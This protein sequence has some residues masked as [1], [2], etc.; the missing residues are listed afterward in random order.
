[1]SDRRREQSTPPP[2]DADALAR[3]T[4]SS[5]FRGYDID[6]VRAYLLAL[7]ED[8]RAMNEHTS[9]LTVELADAEQRATAH[10]E[11]DE[12][13]L[14][15]LLGEETA[16]VLATA[17]EAAASIRTRAD[18]EA[19]RV[20]S[21][22]NEQAT[23]IRTEALSDAIRHRERAETAA[24]AEV[25]A[26]KAHGRQLITDAQA[27]REHVLADLTRRR[28][29][30]RAQ[31]AHLKEGRDR[32]L[33]AYE[34]VRR[35]LEQAV[36]E[37]RTAAPE[38]RAI[39]AAAPAVALSPPVAVDEDESEGIRILT[40]PAPEP[41]PEPV[42]EVVVVVEQVVV[43]DVVVEEVV[44][45]AVI[46]EVAE[47]ITE[48]SPAI[49]SDPTL[50]ESVD[51]L[52]ARIHTARAD[53][54]AKAEEVLADP[55]GSVGDL[56]P[57]EGSTATESSADE[58]EPEAADVVAPIDTF[59]QRAEAL[60]PIEASLTRKLRRV[61]ADEQ[62]E[63]LDRLRQGAKIPGLEALVGSPA[64]HG[65]RYAEAA[66]GDLE[67]AARSGAELLGH[68]DGGGAPDLDDVM[69]ALGAAV[70]EP[71]PRAPRRVLVRRRG[72]ARRGDRA[73]SRRISRMEDATARRRG[74]RCAACRLQPRSVP[75]RARRLHP[76][77]ARGPGSSSM[78]R[79]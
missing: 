55:A 10:V 58:P 29:A 71:L 79:R 53:E 4:F 5:S 14:T 27:L 59:E 74:G 16:R 26:A 48:E 18:A 64:E 17:R 11:L 52:F 1:M 62:N 28:D 25:E 23:A 69:T 8:V 61:L 19:D 12:N 33:G 60:V 34:I 66:H 9:W 30:G 13:R 20:V 24:L 35:T 67:A 36:D 32:L 21:A 65:G 45:V 38:A 56:P 72:R 3:H 77:V 31:I 70:G 75:C 49:A 63:A 44:A 42:A 40:P 7:A 47:E 15:E 37:L 54:V 76:A 78:P 41:E 2:I 6:E 68:P 46:E 57:Q 22:A 50:D 39:D 43:D 51:D 73:G